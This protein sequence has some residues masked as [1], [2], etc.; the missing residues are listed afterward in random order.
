MNKSRK[1][2]TQI[3]A[4]DFTYTR[5]IHPLS[6]FL[7]SKGY[8]VSAS[9][10]S[11]NSSGD[12]LINQFAPVTI[13][14]GRY[15]RSL[16]PAHL[17][18]SWL[19]LIH[20][21]RLSSHQLV[22]VHTPLISYLIRLQFYFPFIRKSRKLIYTVHGFYFHP[23]GNPVSNLIHFLLEL[24]LLPTCNLVFFVSADDYKFASPYLSLLR[25]PHS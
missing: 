11:S 6:L 22:H 10:A 17:L 14:P 13:I 8:S 20:V 25:I 19:S 5:F 4:V 1:S 2:I 18:V 15:F 3:C 24:L 21:L 16:R 23:N 12:L 7:A 9:F